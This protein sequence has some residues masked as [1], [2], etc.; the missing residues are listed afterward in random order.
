MNL[1]AAPFLSFSMPQPTGV[2]ASS[3]PRSPSCGLVGAIAPA[4]AAG[5]TVVAICSEPRV[6]SGLDL[7]EVLGGLRRP[8]RRREPAAGRRRELARR[9]ARTAT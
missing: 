6:R 4:L 2:V 9:W 8:G 3:R 5:N 7:A 1:V